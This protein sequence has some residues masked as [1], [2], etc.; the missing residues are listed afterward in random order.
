MKNYITILFLFP[1]IAFSQQDQAWFKE[2]NKIETHFEYGRYYQ[3]ATGAKSLSKKI[4]K[5]GEFKNY[6]LPL[7]A[8]MCKYN[9][10]IGMRLGNDTLLLD[11]ITKWND[12]REKGTDSLNIMGNLAMATSSFAFQ[13]YKQAQK[14]FDKAFSYIDSINDPEQYW[15]QKIRVARLR[16]FIETMSYNEAKKQIDATIA[17]QKRLSNRSQYVINEKSHK[18]ELTKLKKKEFKKRQTIYGNLL[19]MKGDIALGQ[20]NLNEA[21]S[22]YVKNRAELLKNVKKKDISFLNNSY[23]Y[24]RLRVLQGDPYAALDLKGIR[25]KYAA[26]VR[27][28]IPNLKYLEIFENEIRADAQLENFSKYQKAS[29]QFQREVLNNYPKKSAHIFTGNYLAQL[30]NLAKG[31][32]KTYGKK[33]SKQALDLTNYYGDRDAGQLS[34][35][36]DL[37]NAQK[38]LYNFEGAKETYLKIVD[39][40][41]KNNSDSSSFFYNANLELGAYYLN[42]TTNYTLAD[43][44]FKLYFEEFV[45]KELHPYHPYYGKF[46]N[47][48][49]LINTTLDRF[50]SAIRQYEQLSEII[51]AKYGDLSEEHA[52]VLQRMAKAQVLVGDYPSAEE[53]LL[54]AMAAFKA[55]KK[56]KTQEYVYTQQ[57]IGELYAI[58]GDFEK[59]EKQLNG[60]YQNAKK[61]ETVNEMLPVTMNEGLA[62]L[63][64]ELGKYDN[65]EEILTKTIALKSK[66]LGENNAQLIKAYSLLGQVYLV[67]G[68]LIEA[69]KMIRKAVDIS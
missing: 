8:L 17:Y 56:T 53:N 24:T 67:Q 22:I 5:K 1:V 50:N 7:Q 51:K 64:F 2:Y 20:G 10:A 35:L 43:S 23:G 11:I 26:N 15:A 41:S 3:A 54:K 42:Y 14:H 65:A 49:A 4:E 44:I 46:L 63:Y 47:D 37:A 28:S 25:K 55:E 9:A 12:R 6:K 68:K 40:A 34:F 33:M 16:M 61:F 18:K 69:E 66:K 58:N 45:I 48:Y 29:G 13:N 21:D 52:L 30:E 36:Y 27:Y 62:E 59:S 38:H 39:I 60:A 32:Y 19:V 57:A 31:K